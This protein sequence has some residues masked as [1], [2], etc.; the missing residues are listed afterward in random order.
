[1]IRL[2]RL[3]I[4]QRIRLGFGVVLLLLAASTLVTLGGVGSLTDSLEASARRVSALEGAAVLDREIQD[5]RRRVLN[6]LRT[7]QG[8]A[9]AEV[10]QGLAVL[11]TDTG[12]LAAG[13]ARGDELAAAVA[14]YAEKVEALA[15]V[16]QRRKAGLASLGAL[17]ASLSNAGYAMA[18][19]AEGSP[20][21]AFAAF[22]AERALQATLSAI[23]SARD[24]VN[25]AEADTA[26]VEAARYGREI[27][28]LSRLDGRR[29][30]G[31]ALAVAEGKQA[32][33]QAAV[34]GLLTGL[35]EVQEA[36]QAVRLSGDAAAALGSQARRE[37]AQH[38]DAIMAAVTGSAERLR[39]LV[40]VIGVLAV[41]AGG[42]LAWRVGRA[43]T[44]PLA[45]MTRAME[46]LA[47]GDLAVEV[48]AAARRDEVGAMARA[49]QVFKD[50]LLAK[51]AAE[52]AA[53]R[54]AGTKARRAHL[55]DGL[56]A[57][58]DARMSH[59]TGELARA[60]HAMD[61]AAQAMALTADATAHQSAQAMDA[62][63]RTSSNVHTVA[64]ASATMATSIQ[65][66]SRQAGQS[67]RI[68][69]EA[70]EEAGRTDALVRQLAGTAERIDAVVAIIGAIASQTNLLALNATIEAA[71]AGEAGRGFAVVA[72]EV[73]QLA[74]QTTRA[75]QE[76]S[77]QI[78]EMQ[79]AT[80]ESVRAIGRIGGT[81]VD[82]AQAAAAI[83]AAMDRQDGATRDI[84]RNVEEAA[85]GTA[86][87]SDSIA[88]VRAGAGS[89]ESAAG[90]VLVAAR[91]LS[92]HSAS[93]TAQVRTFLA[94]VKAA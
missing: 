33:F 18:G 57:D 92:D 27:A 89:T 46:H 74:A 64:T 84:T 12:R 94:E 37:A 51:R 7:E 23:R 38:H 81:I 85:C 5:V 48:P 68:A 19:R 58:F 28:A 56:T 20:D 90:Q 31:S 21:L 66:I 91:A 49:V 16:I 87:V 1:M 59:L 55:L 25:P 26:Q 62:A 77:G 17:G 45:G 4:S 53:T 40:L 88:E 34:A 72:A 43:V 8:E 32:A 65:E 82:M 15:A 69:R 6:Y 10:K 79:D 2:D 14:T 86:Q 70:T 30:L 9:L 42:I 63:A 80:Q 36:H 29:V 13:V 83:A 60:A 35:A 78:A 44:R 61:G 11:R 39:G 47:A 93:L 75:T 71:R 24:G 22:R 76:I 52:E 50:A 41:L 67:A 54:D 73:K 3:T